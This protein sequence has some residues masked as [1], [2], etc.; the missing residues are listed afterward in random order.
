MSIPEWGLNGTD[1]PEFINE[2]HSFIADLGNDVGY[3]SYFS[4]AGKVDSDITPV[5]ELRGGV[6]PGL[7]VAEQAAGTGSPHSVVSPR[8][9]S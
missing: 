2:M 7:R 9:G 5:P 4:Y 6:H 8:A 1:D 3:S